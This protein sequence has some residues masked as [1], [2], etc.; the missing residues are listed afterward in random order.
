MGCWQSKQDLKQE[1]EGRPLSKDSLKVPKEN[2][3][4][5]R[6][7]SKQE[8]ESSDKEIAKCQYSHDSTNSNGGVE[9][10]RSFINRISNFRKSKRTSVVQTVD[11]SF[12]ISFSKQ[13]ED[14]TESTA[15]E[16][17]SWASP[18]NGFE[19]MM[20]SKSG[21][22]IF[23]TFLKK[24]F[25]SENLS[26]WTACEELRKVQ[27]ENLL[28]EKVEE[29]FTTYLEASSPQEVSLDFKVREKVL[30]LRDYPSETMFDE[31]QSK[32]YT[33][34][35]RD[36]FPR[37]LTSCFYKDLLDSDL[38]DSKSRD[39]SIKKMDSRT[40]E[41]ESAVKPNTIVIVATMAEKSDSD[42]NSFIQSNFSV[43][44]KP[45]DETE[46]NSK[47]PIPQDPRVIR[48]L[49]KDSPNSFRTVTL[50]TEY[51]KLLHLLQ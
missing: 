46:D 18:N 3:F 29:M 4:N 22:Q 15:E 6:K 11:K 20:S 5:E 48:E 39:N 21:R 14:A 27:D 44:D 36:S 45:S 40:E 17:E 25:S 19:N 24:E 43:E 32:I 42:Q 2:G 31:A 50:D 49:S 7:G 16:V 23:S 37:F 1:E 10:K 28:K 26:F 41:E 38:T 35:H 47:V 33:L 34:M 51:D 13:R 9:K 8:D 12:S 30:E